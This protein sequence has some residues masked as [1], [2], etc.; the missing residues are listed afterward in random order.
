MTE[1]SE[2][3]ILQFCCMYNSCGKG[4]S[5]K[6]NLKRHILSKHSAINRFTCS[7]C[8]KAFAS[9]QNMTEHS[10]THSGFKPYKCLTCNKVFRYASTYS[11]HKRIHLRRQYGK[12]YNSIQL[13]GRKST[14][15]RSS[16]EKT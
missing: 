15:D 1:Q 5:T 12:D 16:F 9:K 10:Y 3:K 6:L 14:L 8:Q 2:F 7:F 13:E 4:Y 11:V